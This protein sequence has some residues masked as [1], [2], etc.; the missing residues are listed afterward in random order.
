LTSIILPAISKSIMAEKSEDNLKR[1]MA[2]HRQK[3]SVKSLLGEAGG[4]FVAAR[5]V[6]SNAKV[7]EADDILRRIDARSAADVRWKNATIN[8]V[9]RKLSNLR[10]LLPKKEQK[11]AMDAISERRR[12]EAELA[13]A[14]LSDDAD[15]EYA[16]RQ[17][18]KNLRD[19]CGRIKRQLV[20]VEEART[21]ATTAALKGNKW[22]QFDDETPK[23]ASVASTIEEANPMSPSERV[24][25]LAKDLAADLSKRKPIIPPPRYR[26]DGSRG[27]QVIQDGSNLGSRGSLFDEDDSELRPEAPSEVGVKA[28]DY[29]SIELMDAALL[30]AAPGDRLSERIGAPFKPS[31]L[32]SGSP[33]EQGFD[34]LEAALLD[35]LN[36]KQ[37]NRRRAHGPYTASGL[38]AYEGGGGDEPTLPFGMAMRPMVGRQLRMKLLGLH[39][40]PTVGAGAGDTT[41]T[42]VLSEV[43]EGRSRRVVEEAQIAQATSLVSG[44]RTESSHL[45]DW[46]RFGPSRHSAP[47]ETHLAL[48]PSVAQAPSHASALTPPTLR[49]HTP[50]RFVSS[51]AEVSSQSQSTSQ[52][53]LCQLKKAPELFAKGELAP[54]LPDAAPATI[55]ADRQASTGAPVA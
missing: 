11:A 5:F 46:E 51:E 24:A 29:I 19:Q 41:T 54:M 20:M 2:T 17:S 30:K 45:A 21:S 50:I 13:A 39:P 44:L 18:R 34:A 23:E 52:S 15:P 49:P 25:Q 42:K 9:K 28:E 55:G 37:T 12:A 27:L 14:L 4:L 7:F 33:D 6:E 38:G 26:F 32:A 47:M 10:E 16:L 8:E 31:T 22:D 1:E 43:V 35:E 48:R 53:F 3:D 40:E 36:A